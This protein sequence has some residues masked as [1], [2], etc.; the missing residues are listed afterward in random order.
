M[1]AAIRKINI[2]KL[3]KLKNLLDPFHQNPVLIQPL[4]MDRKRR[5]L[6]KW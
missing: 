4:R 3:V 5:I 1:T 2:A 6:N